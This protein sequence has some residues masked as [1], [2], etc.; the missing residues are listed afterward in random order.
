[1][2]VYF[3][4]FYESKSQNCTELYR[5][6]LFSPSPLH[7]GL[8]TYERILLLLVSFCFHC[9]VLQIFTSTH[10]PPPCHLTYFLH[11]ILY[12][13]FCTLPFFI[14][15]AHFVGF[16]KSFPRHLFHPFLWL[17]RIIQPGPYCETLIS[18]LLPQWKYFGCMTIHM[19][20]GVVGSKAKCTCDLLDVTK[21]FI[22]LFCTPASDIWE[23]LFSLALLAVSNF[24]NFLLF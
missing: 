15:R 8:T 17:H 5:E 10:I 22:V 20:L 4:I 16:S 11:K 9:S 12:L 7:G 19:S 24:T 14:K 13:L 6:I 21:F 3:K 18:N 2:F 1:M 23:C